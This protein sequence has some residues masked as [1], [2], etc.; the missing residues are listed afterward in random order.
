MQAYTDAHTGW[1]RVGQWISD[2]KDYIAGAAMLI[3][4]GILTACG[5]EPFGPMLIG[6]GVDAIIQRAT[7]GHTSYGQVALSGMLGLVGAG[8]AGAGLRALGSASVNASSA[9]VRGL[10]TRAGSTLAGT[11]LRE[12]V[13]TAAVSGGVS[14][15]GTGAY[16]YM[17]SPGPHTAGGLLAATL[18]GGVTGTFMGG[19]SGAA[20]YGASRLLSYLKPLPNDL[21]DIFSGGHYAKSV[22]LCDTILYRAGNSSTPLGQFFSSEPPVGVIQTRIDKAIPPVWPDGT[23][24]VLDTGYAVKFPAGTITYTGTVANQGGLYMGGTEQILIRKPW[25]ISGVEIVDRWDLK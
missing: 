16:T 6:A 14:G 12:T 4:G 20:G 17:N 9:V 24:S 10:A 13:T 21:A 15:A 2:N 22:L 5:A 3:G 25:C 18:E 11:I 23:P 7:T 19:F 1:N 8:F